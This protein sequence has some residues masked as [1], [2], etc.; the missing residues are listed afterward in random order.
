[1]ENN[2]EYDEITLMN[3]YT[4]YMIYK[5][6]I[7]EISDMYKIHI[8]ELKEIIAPYE[9]FDYIVTENDKKSFCIY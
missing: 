1:M 5:L 8:D 4:F 7:E 9:N 2:F 3:I 6:P